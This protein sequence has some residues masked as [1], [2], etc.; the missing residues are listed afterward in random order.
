MQD[1]VRPDLAGESI[2]LRGLAVRL[3]G[4]GR[5]LVVSEQGQDFVAKLGVA[6]ARCIDHRRALDLGKIA[7]AD[8]DLRGARVK[9][10]VHLPVPSPRDSSRRSQALA[11]LQSF[12]TVRSETSST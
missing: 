6:A 12:L 11:T 8:E 5:D 4:P 10:G 3:A 7:D 1:A 2:G 9:P